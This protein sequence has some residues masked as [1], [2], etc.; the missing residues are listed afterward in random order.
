MI[1]TGETSSHLPKKW[2][3][4]NPIG[5]GAPR[6]NSYLHSWR[7]ELLPVIFM[8]KLLWVSLRV[9]LLSLINL[10]QKNQQNKLAFFLE[11]SQYIDEDKWNIQSPIKKFQGINPML[12]GAP[13]ANYYIHN[14][15]NELFTAM[16]INKSFWS[17]RSVLILTLLKLIQTTINKN[18]LVL[19]ALI[20]LIYLWWKVKYPVTHQ[21]LARY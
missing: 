12:L 18:S 11:S 13:R 15:I 7:D 16:F 8:N 5:P 9:I 17:I 3:G 1:T 6:D 19:L 20:Q 21:E 10:M 2:Q 14:W 4:V